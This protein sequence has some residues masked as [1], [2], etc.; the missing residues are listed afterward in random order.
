MEGNFKHRQHRRLASLNLVNFTHFTA[1]GNADIE[2]LGRTK[3]LAEGGIMMECAQ[4]FPIG[5]T[6]EVQIAIHEDLIIARG[7]IMRVEPIPN[8][9][10]CDIGVKFTKISDKHKNI[11]NHFLS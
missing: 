4:S 3:D 9:K 6:L 11:I 10:K 5:D 2:D 7:E 1:E 8:S